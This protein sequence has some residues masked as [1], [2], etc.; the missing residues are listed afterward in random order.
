[1]SEK[2]NLTD[3]SSLTRL[4]SY[5]FFWNARWNFQD[6]VFGGRIIYMPGLDLSIENGFLLTIAWWGWFVG[7]L[8]V[9]LELVISYS[10][11]NKYAMKE[12]I[13]IMIACWAT[14]FSNN[15]S[16]NTFVFAFLIITSLSINSLTRNKRFTVFKH[17]NKRYI[18]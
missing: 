4:S 14:A 8:K 9:I 11:L 15:N 13:M 17:L 18:F 3:E 16:V 10:C 6:I 12:K 7:P 1:L 5:L 2:N